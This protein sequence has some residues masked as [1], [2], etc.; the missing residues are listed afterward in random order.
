MLTS[1][2]QLQNDISMIKERVFRLVEK[3]S[4]GRKH[5]LLFDYT[6]MTLIVLSLV[7]MILE[8][9]SEVYSEY[10]LFIDGFNVFSIIIFTVEYCMRL[11]VSDL[12]H[13]SKSRLKSLSRFVFSTYGLIDLFAILPFFLPLLKVDLRFLR[14]M[15]LTRF[16]RVL[17]LNRYNDS[18]NLIWTVIKEKKSELAVTGFLSFLIL[19]IAS[20]I[21]YYIEGEKQ[22]EAFPNILESFWWAIAT[23]TTV[24]Y[25]D[26]YPVTGLGKFISGLIAILGIGIVAL[27]TGLISAGF[28]NKIEKPSLNK[29]EDKCPHCGHEIDYHM[30]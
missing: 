23:L 14:A 24:G 27:P 15:R 10:N 26:V 12:T 21:M 13:P 22:P 19:L 9:M 18:L 25:G 7:T 17:K 8:S 29:I 6:I 4:H 1:I 30:N 3:G 5:N 2:I 20:F 11:Y 16:L 28:M